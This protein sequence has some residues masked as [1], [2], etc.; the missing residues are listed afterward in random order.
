MITEDVSTSQIG[1]FR[2]HVITLANALISAGRYIPKTINFVQTRH[3]Q[4]SGCL[5]YTRFF[6]SGVC[7]TTQQEDCAYCIH[8]APGSLRRLV[9]TAAVKRYRRETA[10]TFA[11]R[12]TIFVSNFLRGQFLQAVPSTNPGQTFIVHNFIDLVA[13][14]ISPTTGLVRAGRKNNR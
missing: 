12:K 8:P 13:L 14:R 6:N 1:G 9:S 3:D 4:G 11:R 7:C 2:N 10:N 5:T